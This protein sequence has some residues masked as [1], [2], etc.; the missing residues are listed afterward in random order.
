MRNRE[1]KTKDRY[2]M[3]RSISC[4]SSS[5]KIFKTVLDKQ[6][7]VFDNNEQDTQLLIYDLEQLNKK[8]E[9]TIKEWEKNFECKIERM[10]FIGEIGNECDLL[11]NMFATI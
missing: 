8:H 3:I 7:Q 11:I 4:N 5:K 6:E 1:R 2:V 10:R 9:K